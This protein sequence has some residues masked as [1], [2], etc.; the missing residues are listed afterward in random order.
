[1]TRPQSVPSHECRRSPRSARPEKD[2]A[3]LPG[4]IF[5]CKK[6]QDRKIRGLPGQI[7]S[8]LRS[9]QK[10][11]LSAEENQLCRRPPLPCDHFA[12]YADAR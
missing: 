5:V 4:E 9:E 7:K 6:K 10:G 11:C 12:T 2:D 1:M 8:D 3:R